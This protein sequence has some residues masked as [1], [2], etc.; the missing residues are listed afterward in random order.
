[1]NRKGFTLIELLVAMVVASIVMAA[2]YSVYRS[3]TQT[4]RTQQ[5][6]AQMQQN[7]RAALYL[8]EREIR[9]AGYSVTDP[10]APAGFVQNFASLGSPHDGSGA[11]IDATNIAF[12]VDSDDSGTIDAAA[13]IAGF[14]IIAFR[15]DAANNTLERWDGSSGDWQVAAEQITNLSFTYHR[16]DD[17][18]I[19]FP[20]TAADL[21]DIRSV[22]L[23]ITATSRDRNMNLT[24]KIKCRNMGY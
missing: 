22:E 20:L 6:V 4:Y 5:L 9:M 15:L 12:T 19:P 17:S 7:M 3:Q 18:Q 21:A 13:A 2:I 16:E 8:L 1:M 14:E 10:P 23:A 11:A 24:N